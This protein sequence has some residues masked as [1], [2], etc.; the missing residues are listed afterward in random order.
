MSRL[1]RHWLQDCCAKKEKSVV[2]AMEET[3]KHGVHLFFLADLWEYYTMSKEYYDSR[4]S[5]GLSCCTVLGN[6]H[7]QPV[8]SDALLSPYRRSQVFLIQRF[9][10]CKYSLQRLEC[11]YPLRGRLPFNG[12]SHSNL[13]KKN[14]GKNKWSRIFFVLVFRSSKQLSNVSSS[15]GCSSGSTQTVADTA[16]K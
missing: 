5:G 6:K 10:A 1:H 16:P 3:R 14:L 2:L 12:A 7:K 9:L 8:S 15:G 4:Q 13:K 11:T